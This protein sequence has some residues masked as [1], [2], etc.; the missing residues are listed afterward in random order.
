MQHGPLRDAYL[1]ALGI[2]RWVPRHA[3]AATVIETPALREVS[4]EPVQ[5]LP[6]A[7]VQP[8]PLGPVTDWGVLRE[9]VAACM[10]CELCKTRTQTVFGVGNTS[11]DWLI[12]GE[13]PGAEEDRQGE[14]FVG[15][16][17]QLLNAML[18]AIGLPRETVFIANVLKCRPPGNRDPRPEEV[19]RCL[20][21]LSAQVA[22]LKPRMI[23]V[24]G[25]IA[26]QALLASDAPLARLRGKLHHF[27]D[28]GIPLV[29]TYHPAY[30][31]RTPADKRKAW[32]DLKFARATYL[33][34]TGRA[35]AN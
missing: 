12:I 14:P 35:E 32:E 17:G 31:L 33:R 27:G 3:P 34:Q 8:L 23:L 9:R 11:A 25:R 13:A 19:S 21:Y 5:P 22:L 24:V 18:A 1:D 4:P 7:P 29:I 26:A 20:P 2:D 16:A 15:R 30:L 28:A 6:P 10:A